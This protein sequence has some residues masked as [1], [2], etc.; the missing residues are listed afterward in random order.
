MNTLLLVSRPS[1]HINLAL[2]KEKDSSPLEF[3]VSH[4]TQIG[5]IHKGV[6]LDINKSLGFAFVDFGEK[7]PGLLSRP[8][9]FWEN[10]P[11]TKGSSV[12]VQITRDK[13]KHTSLLIQQEEKEKNVRLNLTLSFSSAFFIF[14]PKTPGLRFSKTISKQDFSEETLSKISEI[15]SDNE[16]LTFKPLAQKAS[17]ETL[18]ADLSILKNLWTLIQEKNKDSKPGLLLPE[19]EYL[20]QYILQ[21]SDSL[22]RIIVDDAALYLSLKKFLEVSLLSSFISLESYLSMTEGP[23]FEKYDIQERWGAQREAII[24][25]SSGHLIL[26]KTSAFWVFD[27]NSSSERNSKKHLTPFQLNALAGQR[28]LEEIRLKNLGG[29]IVVDLIPIQSPS[30]RKKLLTL[31]QKQAQE[32]PLQTHVHNISALGLC[33]ITRP[34]KEPSLL[35]L[36]L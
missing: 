21:N 17:F 25:L 30:E 29:T 23:L 2:L 4:P 3:R 1:H 20:F 6:V 11:F 19:K 22:K 35:D 7:T 27:V 10:I 16:G 32:D 5:D 34:K 18:E 15:L 14:Q 31:I 12:L 28:I 33:E 24:P 9:S 8:P 36:I 26:E 13:V